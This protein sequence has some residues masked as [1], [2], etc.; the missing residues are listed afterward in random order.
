MR[1]FSIVPNY[2]IFEKVTLEYGD[3]AGGWKEEQLN[4]FVCIAA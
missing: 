2:K 4:H 3:L 1:L